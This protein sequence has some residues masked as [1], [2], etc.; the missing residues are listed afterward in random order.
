MHVVLWSDDHIK[1]SKLNLL[2]YQTHISLQVQEVD[3]HF[4]QL[5]TLKNKTGKRKWRE[6]KRAAVTT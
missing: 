5:K 6:M 1:K 2:H 3:L 4:N